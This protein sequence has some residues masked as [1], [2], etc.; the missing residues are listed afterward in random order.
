MVPMDQNDFR[1]L[2]YQ[3]VDWIADYREGLERL[4]VMSQAQPGEGGPNPLAAL[5]HG[6]VAQADDQELNRTADRLDLDVDA[7]RLDALERQG[8]HPRNHAR[9]LIEPTRRSAQAAG[10]RKNKYG[11]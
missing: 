4:P 3:L 1:R 10:L 5:G 6:L 7:L 11:T 9:P 8:D 2:G